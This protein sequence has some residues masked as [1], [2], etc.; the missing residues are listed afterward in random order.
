MRTEEAKLLP[1][2]EDRDTS[3]RWDFDLD[4]LLPKGLHEELDL[5]C[6]L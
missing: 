6:Y 2:G 3:S 5:E 4:S 1:R